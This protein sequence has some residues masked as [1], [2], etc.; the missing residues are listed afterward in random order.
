MK[1]KPS[2]T[3]H[4]QTPQQTQH[5]HAQPSNNQPT[6]VPLCFLGNTPQ[7]KQQ[8]DTLLRLV[9]LVPEHNR[10]FLNWVVVG[11]C[12][13]IFVWVLCSCFGDFFWF[14]FCCA[15]T[16]GGRKLLHDDGYLLPSSEKKPLFLCS[17]VHACSFSFS[18][19]K[20]N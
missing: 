14:I 2:A 3:H 20:Q 15:H 17:H 19:L 8:H 13:F 18:L 16:V 10:V 4:H 12:F 1:S 9:P 11:V 6:L 7:S 5:Y